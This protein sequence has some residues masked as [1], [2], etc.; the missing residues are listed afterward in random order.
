MKHLKILILILC[1]TNVYAHDTEPALFNVINYQT[2]A[3]REIP[4]DTLTAI[5]N[6]EM[7]DTDPTKLAGSVNQIM[8]QSLKITTD[9][10]S[11]KVK[12]GQYQTYPVYIKNKLA[13]WRIR[14]ELRLEGNQFED[15]TNLIGKLQG[16]LQLA[17]LTFS[18]SADA[19]RKI[20]DILTAEA[21][22][23]FKHRAELITSSLTAKTYKIKDMNIQTNEGGARPEMAMRSLA[24]ADSGGA[25]P[26]ALEAG[27]SRISV[28]VSGS[29]KLE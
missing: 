26:P 22:N 29:I 17:R 3:N 23:N 28:L 25:P 13:N 1:T 5:L 18:V 19:Q 12:T 8:R 27:T 4:N 2:Q 21:I 10:K 24:S 15:V 9:Y 14:Q 11:V 16:Q 6:I 7:D 20:E